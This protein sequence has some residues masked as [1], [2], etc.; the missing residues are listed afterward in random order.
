MT[1]LGYKTC[2]DYGSVKAS[3]I[4]Q[5]LPKQ[6]GFGS[7]NLLSSTYLPPNP[8]YLSH[9]PAAHNIFKLICFV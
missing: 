4:Y 9:F 2:E 1:I 6:E 7:H 5:V 8:K 3:S